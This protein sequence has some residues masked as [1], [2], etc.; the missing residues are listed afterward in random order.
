MKSGFVTMIGRPNVGKSSLINAMVG[1]KVSIV[2]PKPQTTRDRIMGVANDEDCQIVFV[3]T[4]G[5]HIA[6][7]KLGEYM[8]KCVKSAMEDLDVLVA[9]FDAS[10]GVSENDIERVKSYAESGYNV[11]VAVNK[12]DLVQVEKTFAILEKFTPLLKNSNVKEIV[13]C[14]VRRSKTVEELKSCI[15]K[16]LPKGDKYFLDGE[17]SDK[18][19][20]YMICEIIREKAL[21]LLQDEIPHGIGVIYQTS[22]YDERKNKTNIECDIVCEKDSSKMII[23]GENGSMIKRIGAS[24]RKDIEKIIGSKVNLKLFVKVR[25]DWRNNYNVIKD[26]GY[27]DK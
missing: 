8:N 26:I 23:I 2:S 22:E 19:I 18:P 25:E 5:I 15:K 12:I 24:A 1:E 7:T 6:R 14:S 3:D 20:S 9:V 27:S 4:P 13:P 17:V 16:Y 10:K 11:I 21:L